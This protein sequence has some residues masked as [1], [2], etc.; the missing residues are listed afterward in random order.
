MKSRPT[1]SL[2]TVVVVPRQRFSIVRRTLPTLLACT[3]PSV[4]IVYVDGGSP[5]PIARFIVKAARERPPFRIVRSEQYLAPNEARNL[6]LLAV[7]TRYVIFADNDVLVAPRW[8]EGL[9]QCAEETGAWVVAPTVCIGEPAFRTIHN[10]GGIAHFEDRPEGRRF[11][12]HHRFSNTL[13]GSVPAA[14]RREQVEFVENHCVMART[15]IFARIGELDEELL[16]ATEHFDFCLRVREGGGTIWFDPASA[17]N[18]LPARRLARADL[19]FYM[20]RWSDRWNQASLRRF[21]EKWRLAEDDPFRLGHYYWITDK[22]M[23]VLGR[24]WRLSRR[25]LGFRRT[26]WA[27]RTFERLVTRFLLPEETRRRAAA[28]RARALAAA[29]LGKEDGTD[30]VKVLEPL[31]GV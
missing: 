13:L 11:I 22:R 10:V 31:A 19:S 16:S 8:V 12:D 30:T 24:A 1:E 6:G 18:Y 14:L 21:C 26:I 7:G 28:R 4:P 2:A 5:A 20:L 3:P 29:G 17:V 9:V 23:L 27:G 25:A 15:D